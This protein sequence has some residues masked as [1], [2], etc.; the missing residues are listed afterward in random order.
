MKSFKIIKIVPT[1]SKRGM[2]PAVILTLR[3][4][5][6][7]EIDVKSSFEVKKH[8]RVGMKVAVAYANGQPVI[9]L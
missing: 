3:S 6:G 2:L 4:K 1:T 8:V 7:E 9:C 5:D